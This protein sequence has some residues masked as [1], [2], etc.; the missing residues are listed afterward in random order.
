MVPQ[1][2]EDGANCWGTQWSSWSMPWRTRGGVHRVFWSYPI[3]HLFS[4]FSL[5]FQLHQILANDVSGAT[6]LYLSSSFAADPMKF[7]PERG[8]DPRPLRAIPRESC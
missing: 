7:G 3:K 8:P 1:L 5:S 4:I 2:V 6:Q